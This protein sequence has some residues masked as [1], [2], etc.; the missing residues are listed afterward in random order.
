M[1]FPWVS[2][3][4]PMV[5]HGSHG[6]TAP[7]IIFVLQLDAHGLQQARD[8]VTVNPGPCREVPGSSHSQ[9]PSMVLVYLWGKWIINITGSWLYKCI[10]WDHLGFE[11]V[12]LCI[13]AYKTGSFMGFLCRDSYSST[14]D[15]LGFFFSKA[16]TVRKSM[17][18][19][20][21]IPVHQMSMDLSFAMKYEHLWPWWNGEFGRC[22]NAEQNHAFALSH[23]L[24]WIN[25]FLQWIL[26]CS[27]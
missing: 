6:C 24:R 17:I 12:Y 27:E 10:I 8:L 3:G 9:V 19:L 21:W 16:M 15:G 13:F 25:V 5:F 7:L 14:M 26:T 2:H 22:R 1:A 20:W 18:N 11:H 4:F 23:P